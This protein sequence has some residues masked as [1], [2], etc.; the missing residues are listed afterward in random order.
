MCGDCK[1]FY[2]ECNISDDYG[3]METCS[4]SDEEIKD[5]FYYSE[6]EIKECSGFEKE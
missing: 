6:E 3:C 5:H 4:H 1:H 2:H